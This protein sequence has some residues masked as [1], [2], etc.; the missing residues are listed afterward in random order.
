MGICCKFEILCKADE[1]DS[2]DDLFTDLYESKVVKLK[3]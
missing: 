1:K 3:F 2:N